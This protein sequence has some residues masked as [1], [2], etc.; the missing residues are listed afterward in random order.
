MR[1]IRAIK[2]K[3]TSFCSC[4]S[5]PASCLTS[6]VENA[7]WCP[8]GQ[9]IDDDLV[10]CCFKDLLVY[11]SVS[12]TLQ[13]APAPASIYICS[14]LIHNLECGLNGMEWNVF[15]SL[16]AFIS[17]RN[18]LP[19]H[20]LLICTNGCSLSGRAHKYQNVEESRSCN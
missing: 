2:R 14:T 18:E 12:G 7:S 10:L 15:A 5:A 3:E 11:S 17:I 1:L 4:S 6:I 9:H 8:F 16:V 13:P 19:S 20:C